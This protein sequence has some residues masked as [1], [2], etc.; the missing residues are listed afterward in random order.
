[1]FIA[2]PAIEHRLSKGCAFQL[3]CIEPRDRHPTSLPGTGLT[4]NPV[5]SVP[6]HIPLSLI[7]LYHGYK[8]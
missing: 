5:L 6:L 4:Q 7:I 1:M 8:S 2:K 3:N